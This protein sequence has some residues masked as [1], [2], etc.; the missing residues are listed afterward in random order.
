LHHVDLVRQLPASERPTPEGLA[1]VRRVAEA[2]LGRDLPGWSDERVA[3]V[4]TGRADPTDEERTD[5][6]DAVVPVFT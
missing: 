3:L 5:L 2:L 1:E 4:A 6:G